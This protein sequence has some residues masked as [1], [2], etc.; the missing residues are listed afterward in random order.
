MYAVGH[1]A[2]GYLTGKTTSKA[3]KVN[4]NM[5]L[6][7]LASIIPDVDLV[8]QAFMPNLITHRV[9]THSIITLTVAMIPFLIIYRKR[10]LPYYVALLS[11]P[12]IGDFFTG[13]VGLFWPFTDKIYGITT[14]DVTSPISISAELIL[15]AVS[16]FIMIYSKDLKAQ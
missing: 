15:F 7:F 14:I 8:L 5:P 16:L 12:L 9:E 6:L 3:L 4:L 11:H 13:G 1:F 2:L 10:A